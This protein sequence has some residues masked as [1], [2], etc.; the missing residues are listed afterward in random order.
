VPCLDR[1]IISGAIVY[2]T[3]TVLAW[4]LAASAVSWL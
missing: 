4:G 3:L 2:S 1:A